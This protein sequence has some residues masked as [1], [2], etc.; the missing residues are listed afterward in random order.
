VVAWLSVWN[1]V[2]MICIWSSWCHCHHIVSCFI[3]IQNSLTFLV[4]AYPGCPGKEAIKWVIVTHTC[5]HTHTH[6]FYGPFSGTTRVSRCQQ[7]SFG[8]CGAREDNRGRHTDHPDEHHSIRTNQWPTSIIPRFY[9]GCPSWHNPP[10]LSWLGTGTKYA[11]CIPSVVVKW[12]S[13]NLLVNLMKF[14]LARMAEEGS[15]ETKLR[16]GRRCGTFI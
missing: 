7:K 4:P 11:D 15:R 14:C 3:E 1:E 2:Q 9:A 8:I 5:T 6:T 10:T 12:V 16:E 13:V